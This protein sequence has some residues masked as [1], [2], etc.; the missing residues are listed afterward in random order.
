[1]DINQDASNEEA[2]K[3]EV[4][5]ETN[6]IGIGEPKYVGSA[7]ID[8]WRYRS[9]PD[10]IM[11]NFFIVPYVFGSPKATDDIDYLEWMNIQ[12][13]IDNE[14]FI[15]VEEH[16]VLFKLLKAYLEKNAELLKG[17]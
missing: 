13:I 9:E 12:Q 14:F 16:K 4:A 11:T 8:D 15:I 3:R 7:R 1:M 10:G 6:S 5:E 17:E 2:V